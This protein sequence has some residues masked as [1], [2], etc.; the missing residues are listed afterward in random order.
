MFGPAGTAKAFLS[1]ACPYT[2]Q[3]GIFMSRNSTIRRAV[4]CALF[5]STTTV[6]YVMSSPPVQ[7]AEGNITEIVVTGS[8]I[9]RPE[10]EASTPVQIINAEAITGQ[11]APNIADILQELPSVGTPGLARTNSNFLTSS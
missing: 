7:A 4:R 8:R 9:A 3:E 10:V 11:G 5:V 2:S 6:L 1:P